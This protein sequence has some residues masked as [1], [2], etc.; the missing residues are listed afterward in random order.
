MGFSLALDDEEVGGTKGALDFIARKAAKQPPVYHSPGTSF[1]LK[2]SPE[3]RIY[4][5]GPPKDEKKIK[6]SDP[7]TA[8]PEVYEDAGEAFGFSGNG[9]A[10]IDED[11]ERPFA[12]CV[13]NV[14]RTSQAYDDLFEKHFPGLLPKPDQVP[15]KVKR[16]DPDWRRLGYES[17]AELEKLALALDGDTNNTSLA[18]AFELDD[19]RVLLFSADARKLET[20]CPGTTIPGPSAGKISMPPIC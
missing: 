10:V 6:K 18:L 17:F 13:G 16:G 4:V 19:G 20:G 11:Y 12:D 15:A 8:H 9:T 5:L 3:C 2:G 1:V 7:S 14:A